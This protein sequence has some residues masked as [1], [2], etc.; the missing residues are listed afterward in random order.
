MAQAR[1][2]QAF[3]Q[4]NGA[5]LQRRGAGDA[6]LCHCHAP[7]RQRSHRPLVGRATV[8][9]RF[10]FSRR[11]RDTGKLAR[12]W[13]KGADNHSWGSIVGAAARRLTLAALMLS[14]ILTSAAVG[15]EAAYLGNDACAGCHEQATAD[16]ADSHH[17][18]AMQEAT[19]ETVLGD[20]NNATFD[21]FGVTTTFSQKG[22]AF[23]IETDN[24]AGELETYPVEYVFGVEPLQQ[25]LLP[26]GNGRCRRSRSP[27]IPGPKA[28]AGNGGITSIPTSTSRPA[29]PCT[30]RAAS[31]TGTPA[32]RNAT[33][34]TSKSAMTR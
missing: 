7:D 13:R 23:F 1:S 16:W 31:L 18:L 28:R 14:N 9:T 22:D 2:H 21:Y 12:R 33:A 17:D 26:L 32:V 5:T 8:G 10:I 20:F 27:G 34:P 11:Q 15:A 6:R 24:A 4:T 30:G 3:G 19:P 29:T 25:Y